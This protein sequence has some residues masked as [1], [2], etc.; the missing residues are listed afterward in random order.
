[1]KSI[2]MLCTAAPGGMSEALAN[3]RRSGLFA[4]LPVRLLITHERTSLPRRLGIALRALGAFLWLLLTVR[5]GL[6]HAHVSMR[7][8]VWRKSVFL[9]L[10]RLARV[11]TVVQLHG[12]AFE[13]FYEE[14]CGPLGRWL[15]RR[16]L[17]GASAVIALSENRRAYLARIAP[18]ARVVV[19]PNMVQVEPLEADMQGTGAAR[20]SNG[21]LFLGEIGKRKGTY[22][23][24]R[25]LAEVAAVRPDVRLVAA[26]SGELEEVRRLASEIGMEER[27]TLPGW[28]SGEEKARL[29]AEA[30]VYVLPSYNEDL[31]VSILE[32]MA[33]GLPVV[34][35]RVGGIPDAVRHGAEGFLTAP[36]TPRE[37]AQ[38]ILRLLSAPELRARMGAS[39]KRR[40]IEQFSPAA[41]LASLEQLYARSANDFGDRVG[42]VVDVLGRERGD[43]HPAGVDGVDGV[44]G[45]QARDLLPVEPG[46]RE[47]AALLQHEVEVG[48]GHPL[49][50]ALHQRPAHGLDALAHLAKFLFPKPSQF[51]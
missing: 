24:V 4:K 49:V 48:A 25:A 40:A 38:Y 45:A 47:H 34:S 37:L 35:T 41:I 13:E 3:L 28:V 44:L 12:S 42:D 27:L 43:A 18:A 32:A 8:S 31:P 11:P 15:V 10:A 29:L 17:E 46:V 22:D 1:V 21:I 33:A 14:E 5:V 20:S 2:V 50:D 39:A 16:M 19:I 23:L 51:S 9:E 30:A 6:V 26:G 7:G 36:G